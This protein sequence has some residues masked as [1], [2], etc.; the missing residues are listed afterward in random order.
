MVEVL[1]VEKELRVE[2][3]VGQETQG[4]VGA[5]HGR[6]VTGVTMKRDRNSAAMYWVT[7]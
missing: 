4:Q 6:G 1:V 2:Q 3:G 7:R 5:A